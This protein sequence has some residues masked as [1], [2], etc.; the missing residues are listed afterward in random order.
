MLPAPFP[1]ISTDGLEFYKKVIRR[2]FGPTCLYGQ[3]IKTRRNNRVIKVERRVMIGA[4]WRLEE[5]L[6]DS[7]DSAK[8][9][10]S[11]SERLNLTIRKGSAY[12]KDDLSRAVEGVS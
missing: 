6:R 12:L 5:A 4:A 2:I 9:N 7:E 1:L 10:T 8:L 3:V 11:F